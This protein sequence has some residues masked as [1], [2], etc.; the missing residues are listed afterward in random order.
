MAASD[1]L[2]L[3][4]DFVSE[5]FFVSDDGSGTASF[6]AMV[7]DLW[8]GLKDEPDSPWRRYTANRERLLSLLVRSGMEAERF[9]EESREADSRPAGA[10]AASAAPVQPDA[11]FVRSEL[12]ELL[13]EVLGLA[14]HQVPAHVRFSQDGPLSLFTANPV[15]GVAAAP[16]LALVEA[17]PVGSWQDLL[18]R[19]AR[20]LPVAVPLPGMADKTTESVST[21]LSALAVGDNPPEFLLVLAGRF[22]LLGAS[23]NWAESRYL[24][25]DLQTVVERHD[26]KQYGELARALACVSAPALLPGPTG[27][28]WFTGVL[29]A[30]VLNAVGV[31]ADLRDGVRES[32]EL[33]A[34]EVV[35]RRA[36]QGLPPLETDREAA[37]LARQSL[38]YLYRI[39]FLLFAEASP[40][41]GILP[42]GVKAYEEGYSLSR[43]RDFAFKEVLD[44]D[45]QG[46]Y[47][48]ESLRLLF[49]L[50]DEGH[51]PEDERAAAGTEGLA[52]AAAAGAGDSL[53]FEPLRADLFAP[54]SISLIDG[55][56]GVGEPGGP[57]VGLGNGV[58]QK[59]LELLLLQRERKGKGRGYVSYATLGINQLGAVY[60]S[61]MSYT[62]SFAKQNQVEVAR[63]G[64]PE[65]GSWLV[66]E[67]PDGMGAVADEYEDFVVSRE[68]DHGREAK[69]YG[70]GEFVFRLSGRDRQRSASY[71]SPEVLTRFTVSQALA[72][73][74]DPV[75][76][77]PPAGERVFAD[78]DT[79]AA[80]APGGLFHGTNVWGEA[81]V[82]RRTSAEEVL[83]LTVCEPAL[84][85]GAFA[86][87]AVR[88]LA[89]EYL[90]R[91]QAELGLRVNPEDYATELQRVKAHIALHNVYGVDLNSTA[92]ELAEVSLWLDT[93]TKGL[94]APWFGLRLRNGN[95]LVGARRT[96]L[97]RSAL[98]ADDKA[99][100]KAKGAAAK[101]LP[102]SLW[103]EAGET[104][105]FSEPLP[106][107]H[108]FQF[109]LPG[110]GWGAAAG[111]KDV[112]Q[113][114]PANAKLLR[115]W[116]AGHTERFS[117]D[118]VEV[119]QRL[120]QRI[121]Q[122]WHLVQRRLELAEADTRR[123]LKVWRADFLP[124]QKR[125]NRATREQIEA[126]LADEDS[127]YQRLRLV[128]DAWCA[129]WFWPVPEDG[130]GCDAADGAA[131]GG[132]AEE[133]GDAAA[134]ASWLP[135]S[136]AK[137]LEACRALLGDFDPHLD[138]EL[139]KA[140]SP[141]ASNIVLGAAEDVAGLSWEQLNAAEELLNLRATGMEPV[142][143][144]RAK[145]PWLDTV[146][147][148]AEEQRFFHWELEFPQVFARGGFDLQV[149]NPPWV[150]PT[151][152]IASLYAEHDP[153]WGLHDK[154][155]EPEKRERLPFTLGLP[156][157]RGSVLRQLGE[158]TALA[159][160]LTAPALY[161]EI[162]GSRPDLYRAFM[163]QTWRH[164]ASGGVTCLLHP[165][166]HFT[167]TQTYPLRE[168]TYAR[169]RR[170][171]GFIN[172]LKLFAEV[173]DLVKYSVNVYGNRRESPL[174]L[175]AV[176]LYHPDT[177]LRSLRHDGS[178]PEPGF[179]DDEGNW[180]LR[181]H[182]ARLQRVDAAVLAVWRDVME[183]PEASP[184]SARMVSAVNASAAAA[185]A[186]LA[187]AP[188]LGEWPHGYSTG[189]DE[190]AG[191]RKG[192]FHSRWGQA[193]S[194]REAILQGP[195]FH[196][197]TPFNKSRNATMRG[198]QDYTPVDLRELPADA[199]PVTEYKP[200]YL[201][202]AEG[203]RSRAEYDAAYGE[204][205]LDEFGSETVPVRDYFRV[206]WRAMAAPTGERTLVPAIFPPG[207]AH[208]HSVFAHGYFGEKGNVRTSLAAASMG[209]LLADFLIRASVGSGISG[210]SVDRL[211]RI[212]EDHPLAPHAL[213]RVLRL[214]CLTEAYAP[215]WEACWDAAFARDAWAGGRERENRPALGGV[216]PKWDT[217]TPLRLDEDRR[218]ALIEL[219]AIMAHVCG[220]EAET[221]ATIYRTQFGV[222][223]NYDLGIGRSG[224]AYRY[225]PDGTLAGKQHPKG[226]GELLDREAGLIQAHAHFAEVL[227]AAGGAGPASGG[228][229]VE[230]ETNGEGTNH[231]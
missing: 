140:V 48:Y 167:D 183:A 109:L 9:A 154:P 206:F 22:A 224:S 178:G 103:Q 146:R 168:A 155:S 17:L 52:D 116:L 44:V 144:V 72:E 76:A 216:G 184:L 204:W 177:V 141:G 57:E 45:R 34:N 187:T 55:Q 165:P 208:V 112:K 95:S 96:V 131:A 159:E 63:G 126:G 218:Q 173:H 129:F 101:R 135:P 50:V 157:A 151:V 46:T 54:G 41:L 5:F 6:G 10:Q 169:L 90:R 91:R 61:L 162:A 85:S 66:P 59:V 128:M 2:N 27:E 209:T 175:N 37:L 14:R 202:P 171:F 113:L 1:A 152:N 195:Y 114:A 133:A 73:L 201:S 221:L 100:A 136:R 220:V 43:L 33:I 86:I 217:A 227:R 56:T 83:K 214:N 47:L 36:Q 104:L 107:G 161:P 81:V 102:K 229:G 26:T 23:A 69:H 89:A 30:S 123:D 156:G 79:A 65:N 24:A 8:A 105:P 215:L 93:M 132:A 11:V 164:Q 149:G 4:G 163:A 166:T 29:A 42:T 31:S 226:A 80:T 170:H 118:Q 223:R 145:H 124:A 15:E 7:R 75:V 192:F 198:N 191:R 182:R 150:R 35:H 32:V 20:T 205:P 189:W 13:L 230:T 158:V 18:A 12:N 19:D 181:P 199:L 228:T 139:A 153:W 148:I 94:S 207:A 64:D 188:K 62:G 138:K 147:D 49:T 186:A 99:A 87:E 67:T 213:L 130:A 137:Y 82:R 88:Q 115:E 176:S 106:K 51:I 160:T 77:E 197:G 193:P 212:P 74:L 190:T 117:N 84:G 60:E 78:A 174:F 210:E 200:L 211:P 179:K 222:L 134:A 28:V 70:E 120:S 25:I 53:R 119:L 38:R 68:T 225:L 39:L 3:V 194:W 219:D 92:V 203:G 121:E 16:S 110:E 172:E 111:Q 108:I 196:I 21:L 143:K 97:S 58:L 142:A 231:G 98:G 180:D 71:Y 127:A 185:L 40:E 125:V 122:L